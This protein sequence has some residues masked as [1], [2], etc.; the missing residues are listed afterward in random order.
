MASRLQRILL[1]ALLAAPAAMAQQSE[2]LDDVVGAD[3]ERRQISEDQLDT[4]NFEFGVFGG[5]LSIDDFGSNAVVGANLAYHISEDFFVE[6][7]YATSEA[8]RT[9]YE[10]LSGSTEL[11]TEDEREYRYYSLNLGYKLFPGQVFIGGKTA[12]NT[13]FYVTAGGGNTDFA[14]NQYFT[15]TLG[16]GYRFYATDWFTLELG[17][18]DHV[19]SHELFGESRQT[20]N[21]E[22]R[23]GLSVFF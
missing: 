22:G 11:L 8:N 1:A 14:D 23:L 5:V 15:Y 18:R 3:I 12:F 6:A 19:F 16:A 21:F 10:L 2:P 20:N 9:S 17:L 7:V 4:E 13:H